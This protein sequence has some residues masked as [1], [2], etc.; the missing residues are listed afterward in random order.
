MK[1]IKEFFKKLKYLLYSYSTKVEIENIEFLFLSKYYIS[2][3]ILDTNLKIFS[4][5]KLVFDDDV[6]NY[7]KGKKYVFYV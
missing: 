1:V 6:T 7:Q 5:G 2:M 3:E 4:N